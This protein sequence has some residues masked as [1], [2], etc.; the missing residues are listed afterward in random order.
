[1]RILPTEIRNKLLER[2]QVESRDAKP[3][4]RVVATQSTVN[5]LLT[6][7]IHTDAAARGGDPVAGICDLYRQRRCEH[8]RAQLSDRSRITVGMELDAWCGGGRCDRVQRR[9]DDQR[10]DPL[11]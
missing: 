1:M 5:T 3:N 4:L 6:E 2:F 8:L 10:E 9:M 7:D 11:L